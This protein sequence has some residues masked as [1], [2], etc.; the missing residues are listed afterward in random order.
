MPRARSC[1]ASRSAGTSRDDGLSYIFRLQSHRMAGRPED[2][3]AAGRAAAQA[4]DRFAQQQFAEGHARGDRPDRADDRPRARDQPEGSPPPSAPAARPAG[5]R[6]RP[7]GPRNGTVPSIAAGQQAGRARPG[8]GPSRTSTRKS[9]EQEEVVLG[10]SPRERPSQPSSTGRADLVLGGTFAD[11]P[12]ARAER[13]PRN[14]LRFDPGGRALRAGSR[15]RGRAG[16][17]PRGPAPAQPGDRPAGADRCA[18]RA[19][20]FASGDAARARP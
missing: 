18:Q 9:L 11:L 15:A 6:D 3:R 5:I 20:P 19:G 10:G 12:F 13:L 2:H 4:A 17:G 16:R 1:Q 7:R 14:A 8:R